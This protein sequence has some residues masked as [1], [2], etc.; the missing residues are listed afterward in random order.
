M[1]RKTDMKYEEDKRETKKDE[2]NLSGNFE[3][4][5][6]GFENRERARERERPSRLSSKEPHQ[7]YTAGLSLQEREGTSGEEVHKCNPSKILH[8]GRNH[9]QSLIKLHHFSTTTLITNVYIYRTLYP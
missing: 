7:V 8:T 1:D 2:E 9:G 6:W 4:N 5:V 3:A